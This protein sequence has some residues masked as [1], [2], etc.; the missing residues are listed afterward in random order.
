MTAVKAHAKTALRKRVKSYGYDSQNR[1]V[2][3]VANPIREYTYDP[4]GRLMKVESPIYRKGKR[5]NAVMEQFAYG[6]S[7]RSRGWMLP[8]WHDVRAQVTDP[9]HRSHLT[10]GS[11]R[12]VDNARIGLAAAGYEMVAAQ[13]RRLDWPGNA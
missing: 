12:S 3:G 10:Y 1:V 2:C 11:G 6:D 5:E 13:P 7:T 8:V 9:L 4:V